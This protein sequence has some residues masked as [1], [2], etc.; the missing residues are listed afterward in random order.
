MTTGGDLTDSGV[1][2]I[3]G[4]AS[5]TTV[6]ANGN[7]ALDQASDI[8]G[9]LSVTTH[10]TGTTSVTNLTGSID[11]GEI[12]TAELTIDARGSPKVE[13]QRLVVHPASL[14]VQMRSLLIKQM[15]LLER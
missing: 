6:G 12:T 15:S 5:F 2:D 10:G 11:L 13:Y 1:L 9:V 8:D 3:S 14:Q 4:A 7:I